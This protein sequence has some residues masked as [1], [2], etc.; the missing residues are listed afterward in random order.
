MQVGLA[1]D[2][3][4]ESK[5]FMAASYGFTVF[6]I[7]GPLC[8][9]GLIILDVIHHFLKELPWLIRGEPNPLHSPPM[10]ARSVGQV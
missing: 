6:A 9:F 5:R 4:K 8:A 7:L 3:L 2:Q 10:G 1:T